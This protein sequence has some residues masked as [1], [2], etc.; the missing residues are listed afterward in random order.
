MGGSCNSGNLDRPIRGIAIKICPHGET[1]EDKTIPIREAQ[2]KGGCKFYAKSRWHEYCWR[3]KKELD[4]C[5]RIDV[6]MEETK[7]QI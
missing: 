5:N 2:E 7:A 4:H 6:P 3:Y 1:R